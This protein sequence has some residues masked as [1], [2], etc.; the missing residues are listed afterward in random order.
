MKKRRLFFGLTFCFLIFSHIPFST[1]AQAQMKQTPKFHLRKSGL[2]LER[3]TQAGSF[4]DVLGRR[5]A[6]FG[7]EHRPLEAW[8]YPLKVLDEFELSFRIEGYPLEFRASDI[9]AHIRVRPEAT[10]FTYSHAAFTVRQIIF[11]PVDE[12]GLIM[13]LDVKSVL[14]MT[15]GVSFRPKL[16]LSWPAGLMTGNVGWNEGQHAYFITEESK[17]F[18]G[19]VGS[20][21]ARDISSMPYQEEP[22]DV[23]TRFEIEASPEELKTSF[24]P[25]IIAGSVEGREKARQ[26]YDH[27]LGS[28][29]SLYEQTVAHYERLQNETTLIRTPDER[30][31]AAF[32]W[33]KV[34]VDKG[35]ATNPFLGTGLVAGFRTSGRSERPGFA[36]YFGRDS[37]WTAL[38]INSYGDFPSTRAA[39]EFLKRFQR[40][41][42]KIPH[43]IS[44]SASL[45]PWFTD[46][47][48]PW[49]S[50]DATPLYVIAH[51]DYWRATGDTEFLRANWDSI[52]KAYRFTEA[53]DTDGNQLVENTKFG[54]GWVEGGPLYPA[55]EEIYMQGLWIEASRGM[56]QLAE[57]LKD[58]AT[59]RR[60]RAAA[61]R[62]RAAM[63][64]TYWLEGRGFY[65][66]ST[67]LPA[68]E[69]PEADPGPNRAVRQARMEELRSARLFD[70]DT[71]LPAVPLWWRTMQDERAQSE[72][73]HLGSGRMATDWGARII[74]DESR[75]YDPLSYHNGSVWPLF[76][77]WASMGAY[78]YGRPHVGY[79]ALM[80]NALLSDTGAL[81][82]V[83]ELL[84]GDFNAPFG[85]SSHH[86]VWSE[87]MIV[88][89]AVRGLLGIEIGAGG[90]ELR[91]APQLP[92]DWDTVEVQNVA[93]GNARYHLKLTR[94]QGRLTVNIDHR[95]TASTST[96][97]QQV[98]RFII[99]PAFPLDAQVR[100]VTVQGRA[101]AYEIK[102]GG[103]VQRAEVVIDVNSKSLELVFSYTEGT[104]VYPVTQSLATGAQ[105]AGLRI[106]RSRA[107]TDALHLLLEG[108]GGRAYTL[109][110]RSP[111]RLEPRGGVTLRAHDMADPELTVAFEGP[112]DAYVR[113]EFVIPINRVAVKR[114]QKK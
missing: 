18:V 85:R 90:K 92:A 31:N 58:T 41:D 16:G 100:K 48:Y 49:A 47:E 37:M 104:D 19:V 38:A 69:P 114:L 84:S 93:A 14:P 86:Q 15:I 105:S 99:A 88:T 26:T 42:G 39:L 63:E 36:W 89:P 106:L 11:A 109:R 107:G 44:Q 56:G 30:L 96:L 27:L 111:Y 76:T 53:S 1:L 20:P 101:T 6:A 45:V 10:I 25:I 13:L 66:F 72:I 24:I 64:Q 32:A 102:S 67:R 70:E 110:V 35:I 59:A 83:T 78:A 34:G 65:A 95:S 79:Q 73:D 50:A 80:A 29:Q 87:A 61:E 17:R 82:Y 113:R 91:F 108:L 9:A 52:Q 112:A 3:R 62:T 46:Y 77:G 75:L 7:Y 55:H 33:A 98:E 5:A 60:A 94:A 74:S 22:R 68:T 2:E 12:A 81:G 71:V 4:Y 51:T 97:S 43:E 57:A 8:V 21:A 23:P 40:A 103:D 54:H 28:V